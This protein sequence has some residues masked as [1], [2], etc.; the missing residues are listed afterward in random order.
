MPL[1]TVAIPRRA[2]NGRG[3][4]GHPLVDKP[5][6]ARGLRQKH[7]PG[8]T[9]YG[10]AHSAELRLPFLETAEVARDGMMAS[11]KVPLGMLAPLSPS[12]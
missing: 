10:F 5:P 8:P 2:R 7:P 11:A 12:K 3:V 6:V 4:I 9:A 1:A